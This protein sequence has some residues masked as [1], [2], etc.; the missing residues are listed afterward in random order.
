M[1]GRSTFLVALLV[2]LGSPFCRAQVDADARGQNPPRLSAL[3]P[4]L[5]TSGQPEG[6]ATFAALKRLGITTVISVDGAPP[7]V[8]TARRY[9]LSYI[10]IPLGYATITPEQAARLI[11]AV[12]LSKGPVL[13]HCHHGRH[14]GPAAAAY[15]ARVTSGWSSQVAL[16]WLQAAGATSKDYPGLLEAVRGLARPPREALDALTPADLPETVS[17]P[18]LVE[19]MIGIDDL[20]RQLREHPEAK[21]ATLLAEAY[22]ELTR[23]P[24]AQQQG[25]VF[26]EM[27]RQAE[28]HADRYAEALA[29][30]RADTREFASRVE[31]SCVA[32]HAMFRNRPR[33]AT[34]ASDPP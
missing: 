20:A 34:D 32:C 13:I 10:H 2:G 7:D 15:C 14:R 19:H 28:Q 12:E 1:L 5:W 23:Q 29:E 8:A 9:G 11:R 22:R 30:E 31:K 18:P 21:T 33:T 6:E 3:T 27:V 24:D 16:D 17:P 26:L 25:D 4:R